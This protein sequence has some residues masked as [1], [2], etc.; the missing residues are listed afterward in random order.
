MMQNYRHI[1]FIGIG[2]IGISALARIALQ[3]G[4]KVSGSDVKSSSIT[5]EMEFLGVRVFIGHSTANL[6][7]LPDLVIRTE[8]LDASA[9]K[10]MDFALS[11]KIPVITYAEALGLLMEGKYGIGITGTNGKSTTTALTAL[12]L[13]KAGLDPTVVLG[14]KISKKNSND[15]FEANARLGK[16]EYVVAELD[17]YKRKMLKAKPKI[18]VLTNIAQDHL[19]YYKDLSDIKHAF[20]EAVNNL[21]LDGVIVYNADDSNTVEIAQRAVCHKLTFGIGHYADLQAVNIKVADGK[22][23]FDLHYKDELVGSFELS[24]PGKYNVSNVL[25]AILVALRLNLDI[26]IV[27][28][29]LKSFAGIWRRFELVGNYEGKPV[30]SDYAHHPDGLTAV[31]GAAKEF[32][33]NKK[34]LYVFQPHQHN[35]T[36]NL[37]G[38]FVTSLFLADDLIVA[39][40]FDVP[41]REHGEQVSSKDI[42]EK[43]NEQGNKAVYAKDLNETEELVKE[44]INNFDLVIFMGA[45]D[46]DEVARKLVS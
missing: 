37:F 41:G 11:K 45:G 17:E 14:S 34:I 43:L 21:P 1:Y 29:T 20:G 22:Q 12:I 6:S 26:D 15:K 24:I 36:K 2:G 32:Y 35:R 27:K 16:S 13:D 40:I 7:D 30:F 25:G 18:L 42:V 28:R 9:S 38:D 5:K 31:I 3:Q 4:T 44:K 46:I 19:D 10:E 8:D 23:T 33:P 39:E